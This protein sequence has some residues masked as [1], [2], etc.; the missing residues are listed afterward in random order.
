M[1][2]GVLQ[3]R[4]AVGLL[5]RADYL[6]LGGNGATRVIQQSREFPHYAFA[7]SG[8]LEREQIA[9]LRAALLSATAATRELR[10]RYASPGGIRATGPAA[11][12]GLEALLANE[13]EFRIPE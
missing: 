11:F 3:G 1:L 9:R 2:R 10:Q 4:C 8:L 13:W 7:A 5:P 12:A 6:R